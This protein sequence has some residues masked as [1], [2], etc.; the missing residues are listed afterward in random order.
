MSS[1]LKIRQAQRADAE[2]I[3]AFNRS[4]A[5]ETEGI[6]LKYSTI[7]SG[8][9]A[10]LDDPDK[11]FYLV[12]ETEGE[13]IGSLMITFE[14]SDWRNGNIWWF[15]SV[16]VEPEHRRKGVFTKLFNEVIKRIEDDAEIAGAR[17]YVDKH[18]TAAIKT[19]LSQGMDLSNYQMLELMK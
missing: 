7:Q 16:Y 1:E 14:W 4:M 12:C 9:H 17:L 11:G 8:V 19:Y 2:K 3:I 10:V 15:Q 6:E 5:Q 18:N 13:V